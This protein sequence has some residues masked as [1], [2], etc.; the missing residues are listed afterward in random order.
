MLTV[1]GTPGALAHVARAR[2]NSFF[3]RPADATQGKGKRHHGQLDTGFCLPGQSHL[4][5]SAT[6]VA[7]GK[8]FKSRQVMDAGRLAA[9]GALWA[10]LVLALTLPLCSRSA[11]QASMVE[12]LTRKV[13]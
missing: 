7:A 3:V 5:Q 4:R 13:L 6:P 8:F 12:R 2:E 11:N 1:P 10:E 9:P